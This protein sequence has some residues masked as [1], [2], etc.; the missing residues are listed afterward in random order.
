[1]TLQLAEF[2]RH[3]LGLEA[4]RKVTLDAEITAGDA[5]PG[6]R[7]GA[8][9]RAPDGGAAI[10][11]PRRAACLLPPMILQPLVENAVKHGI[12]NLPE[13]GTVRISARARRLD[14]ARQRSRTTSTRTSAGRAG[15]AASAWP[16]CASAWRPSMATRPASTGRAT[17]T[18][19]GSSWRCPQKRRRHDMRVMI[20]DDEDLARGLVREFLAAHADIEIVAE[21]ANGFDAVKAITELE[22][23]LV[24]LDIQMPKLNGFEVVELAG[25]KTHY[26]FVTAYDQYALKAFEVHAVDYLLKPFSQQRFDQALAHA[27]AQPAAPA[28][29]VGAMVSEAARA[30]RAARAGADPRRRQGA[31]DRAP[32]RSTSSKRRTTTCRSTPKARPT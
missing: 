25:G 30:Q 17:T 6:D 3:T 28:R 8:L 26:V 16:T 5:F 19:S 12:G 29:R 11:T 1:M 24:F 27:R 15:Q 23:D 32:T 21:C 4:H 31:R 22:P 18:N 10:S 7:K 14:P 20:V 2:F 13:G 9:R